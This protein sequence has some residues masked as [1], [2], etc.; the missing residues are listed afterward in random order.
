MYGYK[1]IRILFICLCLTFMGMPLV[2]SVSADERF[3]QPSDISDEET[4]A[5]LE[6]ACRDASNLNISEPIVKEDGKYYYFY[7]KVDGGDGKQIVFDC[8]AFG[9][10][11]VVEELLS[12]FIVQTPYAQEA[13]CRENGENEVLASML[14]ISTSLKSEVDNYYCEQNKSKS[15]GKELACNFAR[16]AI[17]I[18]TFGIGAALAGAFSKKD[19][20]KQGCLDLSRGDCATNAIAGI[21]KNVFLN[22]EGLW[23]LGK[24]AVK[25]VQWGAGKAWGGIKSFFGYGEVQAAEDKSAEG[26]HNAAQL[27]DA[28]VEESQKNPLAFVMNFGNKVYN[29]VHEYIAN[30]FTCEEWSGV[31]HASKCLKPMKD[32]ACANC[33]QKMSA[34]CGTIGLIG[35][36]IVTAF[37]TGGAINLASRLGKAT[38]I[39]KL[40]GGAVK[41]GK[42]GAKS[43]LGKIV[44]GLG[45]AVVYLP[46]KALEKIGKIPGIKQFVHLNEKAFMKGLAMGSKGGKVAFSAGKV[47]NMSDDISDLQK[48]AMKAELKFM[49]DADNLS[50]FSK[51]ES[52]MMKARNQA[53]IEDLSIK[54][55]KFMGSAPKDSEFT[56]IVDDMDVPTVGKKQVKN[57][58]APD[59][60]EEKVFKESKNLSNEVTGRNAQIRAPE[61]DKIEKFD[62]TLSNRSKEY[63][64]FEDIPYKKEG[65]DLVVTPSEKNPLGTIAKELEE[66]GTKLK[67]SPR[68]TRDTSL[69]HGLYGSFDPK[70]NSIAVDPYLLSNRK[71][72]DD[73]AMGARH[74]M[75]A[76]PPA[77]SKNVSSAK[78]KLED[79]IAE[80][81]KTEENLLKKGGPRGRD[82]SFGIGR[83][84]KVDAARK[85]VENAYQDVAHAQRNGEHPMVV[86]QQRDNAIKRAIGD[87]RSVQNLYE[88]HFAGA[89]KEY[90]ML[91]ARER[92]IKKIQPDEI[93]TFSG[94]YLK[95]TEEYFE[96]QQVPYSKKGKSLVVKPEG[97]HP[98]AIVAKDLKKRGI[99][100]KVSPEEMVK[101]YW[102][103]G[104]D[105]NG[106]GKLVYDPS[107]KT[108]FVPPTMLSSRD[109]LYKLGL[110][111]RSRLLGFNHPTEPGA[112]KAI[113]EKSRG[114]VTKYEEAIKKGK[115]A[116]RGGYETILPD[117]RKRLLED[118][119]TLKALQSDGSNPLLDDY[120]IYRDTH[121]AQGK[122]IKNSLEEIGFGKI[123]DEIH[124][125]HRYGR[126][127]NGN[128][129]T[130]E[131]IHRQMVSNTHDYFDV[132]GIKFTETKGV[133]GNK[134]F[135]ILPEGD[136]AVNKLAAI[137]NE[138]GVK[139]KV[140]PDLALSYPTRSSGPIYDN[141]RAVLYLTPGEFRNYHKMQDHVFQLENGMLE[142]GQYIGKGD[143]VTDF[144]FRRGVAS[145]ADKSVVNT[146]GK[147]QDGRRFAS[148]ELNEALDEVHKFKERTRKSTK[149]KENIPDAPVDKELMV[150][151]VY[152]AVRVDEFKPQSQR[153]NDIRSELRTRINASLKG[154]DKVKTMNLRAI[155]DN[156]RLDDA[157]MAWDTDA[158][159]SF[160]DDYPKSYVSDVQ[161]LSDKVKKLRQSNPDLKIYVH[162][163]KIL[164]PHQYIDGVGEMR[165]GF[166]VYDPKT[167]EMFEHSRAFQFELDGDEMFNP[168]FYYPN[169]P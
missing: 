158:K 77:R 33:G 89:K 70:T 17:N 163:T 84:Q 23:E 6:S 100:L 79:A 62:K 39:S 141:E 142:W 47:A 54:K 60:F 139:V 10:G 63:F 11:P 106:Y 8:S 21:I 87:D 157:F 125:H 67:V 68:Q 59:K 152:R 115:V 156:E 93:K 71:A 80:L 16:T 126:L 116:E 58:D 25:G 128:A 129:E 56:K 111:A 159:R 5:R 37:L 135:D 38:K 98:L 101:S 31:P 140:D 145:G 52:K 36:E 167:N 137:M 113:V 121:I 112:M 19:V 35:G 73:L 166:Y 120:I 97:E 24:L 7:L 44:G 124:T 61:A 55:D 168:G 99:E 161:K 12:D 133:H 14:S 4:M 32:F 20:A 26:L 169:G 132:R 123:A 86:A 138:K 147:T 92:V 28:D 103:R 155:K 15:C 107:S 153:F 57:V 91:T 1:E 51:A 74:R 149:V 9:V 134:A 85:K 88:H 114:Q 83:E 90:E 143:V 2:P 144:K 110:E 30:N 48:A 146:A 65:S 148:S 42:A 102:T 81:R 117:S 154:E 46:L 131:K 27:S 13:S 136:E 50:P 165:V 49:D 109:E 130:V 162:E 108:A 18:G 164:G 160:W 127:S 78:K 151:E 53:R 94:N 95:K 150:D 45:K 41:I 104:T 76:P 72:M 22:I 64:D 40:V 82:D 3:G 34:I 119:A 29:M 118:E 75:A 69:K 122:P 43:K 105:N 66:T 96:L